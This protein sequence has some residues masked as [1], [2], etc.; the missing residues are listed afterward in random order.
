MGLFGEKKSKE[1]I[2]DILSK[3]G[4]EV[5]KKLYAGNA[6]LGSP[7][8]YVDEAHEKWAVVKN[9]KTPPKIYNFNDILG[10]EILENGGS[11]LKGHAGS[12]VVGGLLFGAVGA[13]AGAS[14]KKKEISTC[15]SLTLSITINDSAFPRLILPF[16]SSEVKTDSLLYKSAIETAKTI[17]SQLEYMQNKGKD[18]K[19]AQTESSADEI[20]KFKSLLDDG[21]ITQEEFEAKKKQLLGL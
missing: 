1:D 12:A 17:S 20:K 2:S 19:P 13:I 16:I 21:V 4:F 5:S 8:L 14:R 9:K 10:Y 6:L 7:S 18:I 3:Q 11:I 15:K